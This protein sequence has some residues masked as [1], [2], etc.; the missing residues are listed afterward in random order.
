M[1]EHYKNIDE[2][3]NAELAKAIRESDCWNPDLNKELVLRADKIELGLLKCYD[4]EE[5]F[6]QVVEKAADVL[7][8]EIY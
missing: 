5:E 8:V 4:E 3:T 6:E 7:N 2:L 1:K